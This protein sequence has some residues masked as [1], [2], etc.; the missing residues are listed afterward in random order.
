[1]KICF[2]AISCFIDLVG[3]ISMLSLFLD[4]T[5]S[6]IVMNRSTSFDVRRQISSSAATPTTAIPQSR[7]TF[8]STGQLNEKQKR[9]LYINIKIALL[10]L[11]IMVS[12][13]VYIFICWSYNILGLHYR[14]WLTS[15]PIEDRF[16][17]LNIS[18]WMMDCLF[19]NLV[20]YLN[21]HHTDKLYW[22]LCSKCHLRLNKICERIAQKKI[23]K[24]VA[25][26]V[27]NLPKDV[28]IEYRKMTDHK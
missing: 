1:M 20:I 23:R 10:S 26:L 25:D 2:E 4:K 16:F 24:A 27:V 22:R 19:S 14:A 11:L 21:F 7:L 15:K 3:S 18:Y 17:Y 13:E 9:L 8:L 28:E 12:Y 6:V 5:F